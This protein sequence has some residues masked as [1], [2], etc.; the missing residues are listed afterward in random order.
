MII[1]TI[2]NISQYTELHPDLPKVLTQ[3]AAI[4]PLTADAGRYNIPE[5]EAFFMIQ[6]YE[7]KDVSKG[8]WEAHRKFIDVQYV[9]SGIELIGYKEISALQETVKYS[10][11]SDAAFLQGDGDF[12]LMGEGMC[13]ILYPQDAH[14]PC[15]SV[16]TSCPVIKIVGKL[17]V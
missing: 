5:S 2:N 14:M 1:D 3:M 6:K 10:E 12:L 16:N 9:V 4:D 17:P 7:T 11:K 8:L 15:I 13:M